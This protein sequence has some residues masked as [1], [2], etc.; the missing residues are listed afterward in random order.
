M[1]GLLLSK[2]FLGI[3]VPLIFIHKGHEHKGK[4]H[5]FYILAEPKCGELGSAELFF[6]E[7]SDITFLAHMYKNHNVMY[8]ICIHTGYVYIYFMHI[9]HTHQYF[10]KD[11]H[12]LMH[13]FFCVLRG[14][15]EHSL[16]LSTKN[17]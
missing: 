9:K 12:L 2:S 13:V 11:M 8:I 3:K 4:C 1:R 10:K 17:T 14:H 15:L 6:L 16:I 5:H 7:K